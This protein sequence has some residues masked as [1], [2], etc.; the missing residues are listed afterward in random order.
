[1]PKIDYSTSRYPDWPCTEIRWDISVT[2]LLI[3]LSRL[4]QVKLR[5]QSAGVL[6]SY[7]SATQNCHRPVP[8]HLVS[9]IQVH[10]IQKRYH[11][12]NLCYIY[13]RSL[14]LL[15][16]R[17]FWQSRRISN[18]PGSLTECFQE[19]YL[20]KCEV[21]TSWVRRTLV[22]EALYHAEAVGDTGACGSV[23]DKVHSLRAARLS[24]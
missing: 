13:L 4:L 18:A 6:N 17:C 1:M 11:C 9:E 7:E 8:E 15:L 3:F 21:V 10:L 14:M 5:R 19:L 12:R 20:V 22:W 24:R 23:C 2:I 16:D